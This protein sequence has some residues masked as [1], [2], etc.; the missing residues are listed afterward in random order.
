MSSPYQVCMKG[1]P[2]LLFGMAIMLFF[3]SIISELPR[4]YLVGSYEVA[5]IRNERTGALFSAL[6]NA[7]YNAAFPLFGAAFLHR[8]DQF[9]ARAS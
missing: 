6:A 7:L 4:L 2:K 3:A 8:V 9:L 5:E 1:A